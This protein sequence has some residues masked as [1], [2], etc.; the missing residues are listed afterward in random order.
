MDVDFKEIKKLGVKHIIIDLDLTLRKKLQ[1]RL[2]PA[3]I[4]F[5]KDIKKSNNF[6]SLSIASNNMLNLAAYGKPIDAAIFQPFWKGW[7]IARKPSRLFYQKILDSLNAKPSECVMIGDKLLGDVY[8]GNANGLFTVLV[9]PKGNDY[10]YDR[11]LLTRF[12]E[13]RKLANYLD[14]AE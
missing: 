9:K 4:K 10:W 5:L 3:T 14:P 7:W 6:A 11:I 12:R 1:H 13:K 2:E 8:G